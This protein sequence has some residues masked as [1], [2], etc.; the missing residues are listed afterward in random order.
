M[1]MAGQVVTVIRDQY[2]AWKKWK[3]ALIVCS[4]GFISGIVYITP[5]N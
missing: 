1:C 3:V 5:V 2:P 4:L